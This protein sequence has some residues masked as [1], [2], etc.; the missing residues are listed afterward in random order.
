MSRLEVTMH[1]VSLMTI[2]NCRHNLNTQKHT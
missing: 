1:D 2:L